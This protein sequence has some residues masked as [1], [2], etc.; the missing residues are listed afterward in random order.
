VSYDRGRILNDRRFLYFLRND[1]LICL[2]VYG[3]FFRFALYSG[4]TFPAPSGTHSW[5]IIALDFDYYL[6][7]PNGFVHLYAQTSYPSMF[8]NQ[9]FGSSLWN[10]RLSAAKCVASVLLFSPF[11]PFFAHFGLG[12]CILSRPGLLCSSAKVSCVPSVRRILL[13]SHL[14]LV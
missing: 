14:I 7:S 1:G 6:F 8:R 11:L 3:R 9:N 13:A 5:R 4:C 12:S 10:Q 2:L